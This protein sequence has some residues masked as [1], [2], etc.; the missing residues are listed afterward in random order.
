[1]TILQS[2]G[3]QSWN[4]CTL[5]GV[6][7][8]L[9]DLLLDD[10]EDVRDKAA[11]VASI[12]LSTSTNGAAIPNISLMPPAASLSL[13]QYMK[14]EFNESE[15]LFAEAA[16]RL[17]GACS[18]FKR[19][20]LEIATPGLNDHETNNSAEKTSDTERMP[21]DF[22]RPVR[23]MVQEVRRQDN[24]LFAEEKQNL[25][26]DPVK[27]AENWALVLM[28]SIQL[29]KVVSIISAIENW[30]M[31]GLEVLV[32]TANEKD[33][34][35]GWTTKPDVFIVG[36]RILLAA[37]VQIHW[38]RAGLNRE[39][40]LNNILGLLRTLLDIGTEKLLNGIW[41]RQIEGI[42]LQETT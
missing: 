11:A 13:L 14:T 12:F 29:E 39:T 3:F 4:T 23:E 7:I 17:T 21:F 34:P 8:V 1:M 16:Y 42:L 38:L 9:Y 10:D 32:E 18:L 31:E 28:N 35:L 26:V 5:I 20:P 36:M 33:G 2:H 27:E 15:F 24:A 40:F 19:G 30:T 25:F 22:I 6:Y 37:K 41:L